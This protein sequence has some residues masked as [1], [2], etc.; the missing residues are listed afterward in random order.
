MD[1]YVYYR[2]QDARSTELQARA[3]TLQHDLARACGVR[4]RLQRR[5]ASTNGC[6]TWMEVYLD[7]PVHFDAALERAVAAADLLS[8]IDGERHV[9][10]FL[11]CSSCA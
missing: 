7:V 1:V 9:E 3:Q 5:P 6:Q 11:D 2:V 4:T 8:V 10:Y